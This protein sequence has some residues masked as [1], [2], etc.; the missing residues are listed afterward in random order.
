MKIGVAYNAKDQLCRVAWLGNCRTPLI[1]QAGLQTSPASFSHLACPRA[2]DIGHQFLDHF[3]YWWLWALWRSGYIGSHSQMLLAV[4]CA[5]VST[6]SHL[7]LKENVFR[8]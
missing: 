6:L 3:E 4:L 5:T 7:I 2:V 8:L 1:F